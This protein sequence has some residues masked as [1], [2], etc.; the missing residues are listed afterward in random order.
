MVP[1]TGSPTTVD[2]KKVTEF[3]KNNL[4]LAV[5]NESLLYCKNDQVTL[6]FVDR[7]HDNSK[8]GKLLGSA[9]LC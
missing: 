4:N 3:D 7:F 6:R 1:N 5:K 2:L 9:E 8:S